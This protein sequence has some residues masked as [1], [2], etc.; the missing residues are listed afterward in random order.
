MSDKDLAK[1][2]IK[3]S[4][5]YLRI[6]AFVLTIVMGFSLALYPTELSEARAVSHEAFAFIGANG[7]ERG[8]RQRAYRRRAEIYSPLSRRNTFRNKIYYRGCA[9]SWRF[10]G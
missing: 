6:G 10:R 3:A 7:N 1:N 9:Y 4:A 8:L 5:W 2:A